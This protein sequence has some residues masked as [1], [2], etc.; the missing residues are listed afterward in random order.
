MIS[1]LLCTFEDFRIGSKNYHNFSGAYK[2]NKYFRIL[3]I[4]ALVFITFLVC[5]SRVYLEYH[6]PEQVSV[7]AIIGVLWGVFYYHFSVRLEPIVDMFKNSYLGKSL[8]V[9]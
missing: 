3:E 7:G 2:L 6:T 5:A 4:T 1:A 9:E 8:K